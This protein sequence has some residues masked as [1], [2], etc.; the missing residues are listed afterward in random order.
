M[1]GESLS[2]IRELVSFC[3][4]S[5]YTAVR[6]VTHRIRELSQLISFYLYSCHSAI[7]WVTPWI[8]ELIQVI[9]FNPDSCHSAFRWVTPWIRELSQVISFNPVQ[10]SFCCQVSHY[11]DQRAESANPIQPVHCTATIL[12]SGGSL[13]RSESWISWSVSTYTAAILLSGEPLLENRQQQ[14]LAKFYLFDN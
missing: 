1:P 8:R 9:S 4:Y 5:Y 10:L 2:G 6:W 14:L 13:L 3:L 7:R 11:L 12:L